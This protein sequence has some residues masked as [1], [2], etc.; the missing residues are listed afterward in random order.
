MMNAVGRD[1]KMRGMSGTEKDRDGKQQR[2]GSIVLMLYVSS[3]S[4]SRSTS[5]S[6]RPIWYDERSSSATSP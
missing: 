2:V 6:N 1:A 4:S 5:A 3:L